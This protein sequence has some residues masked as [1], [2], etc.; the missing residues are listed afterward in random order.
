MVIGISISFLL[1]FTL[2]PAA[3]ML[4]PRL[5]SNAKTDVTGKITAG[6]ADFIQHKSRATVLIFVVMVLIALSGLPRLSVEN[7]FIDYYK[8]DTEIYQGMTLI[9]EKLGGTTPMDVII[10]APEDEVLQED[11][12]DENGDITANSYWFNRDGL[13]EVAKIHQYL[14]ELPETGKILSVHTGIKMLESL[15]NGRPYS[16]FKLAV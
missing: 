6:I 1:A 8:D 14:D 13:M 9:D 16:D 12:L 4:L 11:E 7:R 2:F 5:D 10:D 3:L 15:N